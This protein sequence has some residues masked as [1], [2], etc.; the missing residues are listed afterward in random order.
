MKRYE[1]QY[2]KGE[3]VSGGS[4]DVSM[5]HG[6][7]LYYVLGQISSVDSTV[8]SLAAT[9]NGG[10]LLSVADDSTKF[11]K[12]LGSTATAY[13]PT[14]TAITS[15]K[16]L[17]DSHIHYTFAESNGQDLPSF[18]LEVTYE[19]E[20]IVNGQYYVGSNDRL[21]ATSGNDDTLK[22]FETSHTEIYSRVFTGCQVNSTT[23]SFDEGQE[24]KQTLDL[25]TRS[26]FDVPNGYVPKR[27]V[28]EP[29]DLHNYTGDGTLALDANDRRPYL[30]SEGSITLFGNT[31]A[32]VKSGSITIS[33]NI[34]PQ[35]CLL[36]TSPSPR[37]RQKS[38]MP[39]SA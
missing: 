11:Y 30:F 8:G 13:P 5:S 21:T 35:S 33:N 27:L 22:N 29:K 15:L 28:R 37:D 23:I 16:L 6:G 26:A 12:A 34:T 38:R 10:K 3:T 2:K 24:V 19:K 7:W 31:V 4:L 32:R 9:G 20:G 36:Y 39:S 17:T 1:L 25:V 18:A 14:S